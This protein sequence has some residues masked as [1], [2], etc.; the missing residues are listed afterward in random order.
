MSLVYRSPSFDALVYVGCMSRMFVESRGRGGSS[1]KNPQLN[2]LR[3]VSYLVW[4][5]VWL[6]NAHHGVTAFVTSVHVA[7]GFGD[8]LE[9]KLPFNCCPQ[10]AL[11]G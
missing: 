5:D 1:Q 8:L 11:L 7:M 10:Y 2:Q 3:V 6:G 4:L 9:R